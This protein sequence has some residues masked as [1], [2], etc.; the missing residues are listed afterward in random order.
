MSE[1][2]VNMPFRTLQQAGYTVYKDRSFFWMW[3]WIHWNGQKSSRKFRIRSSPIIWSHI[4]RITD[5][6]WQKMTKV[7][8]CFE[9]FPCQNIHQGGSEHWIQSSKISRVPFRKFQ[10]KRWNIS[11]RNQ[12]STSSF[13]YSYFVPYCFVH[14]SKPKKRTWIP[15][16]HEDC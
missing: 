7:S 14:C 5:K 8:T 3:Q 11:C 10:E 6:R 9:Q 4:A 1:L 16:K 12:V 2:Q 13:S 15:G